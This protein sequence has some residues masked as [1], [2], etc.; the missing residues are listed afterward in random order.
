M[1]ELASLPCCSVSLIGSAF[2]SI[3]I[4]H[5][6]KASPV[7]CYKKSSFPAIIRG[8]PRI[9]ILSVKVSKNTQYTVRYDEAGNI[10]LSFRE[11]PVVGRG[12]V[13]P[14]KSVGE[15]FIFL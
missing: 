13:P 8:N 5:I 12:G 14:A 6:L 1:K 3:D 4:L 10:V 7:F 11:L 2:S 15:I 9:S